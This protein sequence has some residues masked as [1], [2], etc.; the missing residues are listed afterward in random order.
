MGRL[1]E[2]MYSAGWLRKIKENL[3]RAVD[4]VGKIE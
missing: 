1:D 4:K 3:L 2:A